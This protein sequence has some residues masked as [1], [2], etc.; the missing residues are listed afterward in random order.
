MS[1]VLVTGGLGQIG[2]YVV[3]RLS[4]E[5]EVTVIDNF[6]S[7]AVDVAP[8]NVEVIRADV[9][10]PKIQDV[11]SK[12]DIII[13]TAAQISVERSVQ[14]PLFDALNNINGTIN[15][16][17]GARLG[18]VERFIYLSSAAVFG[19]PVRLPI[20]E[21]HPQN[22]LSPYGVS[23]LGGEKY[24]MAYYYTY[25][26]PTVCIRLFNIYS[27][28]QNPNSPYS[29]VISKFIDRVI[30]GKPPI[31][32]G[33][34]L[35]TRDF[36]S[37]HDIVDM[38][39]IVMEEGEAKGEVYNVGTGTMISIYD[40]AKTIIGLSGKDLDVGYGKPRK[41]DIIESYADISKAK[42]IGYDPKIKLKDGLNELILN[43]IC[44]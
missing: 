40:L 38:I 12:N 8:D 26:L 36:V 7:S 13:H 10:D 9:Q 21:L 25:G 33:D 3:E 20:D 27:P 31:I 32:L 4:D 2:S 29:G 15:L 30:T 37:V 39:S 43:L 24:C 44:I 11:V 41:G 14:D 18:S 35:Q 16:L 22:P 42:N 17:E 23:K 6:S 34:G 28:R 1:K 19:E 5:H